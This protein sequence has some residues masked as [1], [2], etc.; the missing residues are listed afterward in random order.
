V[1]Q[2]LKT[3]LKPDQRFAADNAAVALHKYS[4]KQVLR[5]QVLLAKVLQQTATLQQ[6]LD[7]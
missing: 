7:L 2:V 6:R 1:H 5:D 4:A 3:I